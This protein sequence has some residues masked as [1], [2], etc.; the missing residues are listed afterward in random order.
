MSFCSLVLPVIEKGKKYVKPGVQPPK[1]VTLH[2]GK[3]GG[4]FYYIEDKHLKN[5]GKEHELVRSKGV[6]ETQFKDI[7][8]HFKS[9]GAESVHFVHKP[10]VERNAK[11]QKLYNVYIRHKDTDQKL[12][13][14]AEKDKARYGHPKKKP[15]IT[16]EQQHQA[17]MGTKSPK[18]YLS[19][20]LRQMHPEAPQ[21]AIESGTRTAVAKYNHSI[22][23]KKPEP[24]SDA[25]RSGHM[26]TSV[27]KVNPPQYTTVDDV[28]S[29]IMAER[30][31]LDQIK[32]DN[33]TRR[34]FTENLSGMPFS[35]WSDE[36]GNFYR[37]VK[38]PGKDKTTNLREAQQHKAN[39][40]K[41]VESNGAYILLEPEPDAE[42]RIKRSTEAI[43]KKQDP[44]KQVF[45]KIK[46]RISE[47]LD[48]TQSKEKFTHPGVVKLTSNTYYGRDQLTK[49][50]WKYDPDRR[51]W[52]K[53][54][55]NQAEL[56]QAMH[57]MFRYGAVYIPEDPRLKAEEEARKQTPSF[58]EEP[59]REPFLTPHY[60]GQKEIRTNAP[61]D[62]QKDQINDLK[63][64][65]WRYD[66]R[67]KSWVKPIKNESDWN[68][69]NKWLNKRNLL[70]SNTDWNNWNKFEKDRQ[71]WYDNHSPQAKKQKTNVISITHNAM[72]RRGWVSRM[73]SYQ[74][75]Q[76]IDN[77]YG[78]DF[79][80]PSE[81]TNG[82]N[83]Y[84][85]L[86]DGLYE[87]RGSDD[88][89]AG[90][91]VIQNGQKHEITTAEF[92]DKLR[93]MPTM[94]EKL[95]HLTTFEKPV[96][97]FLHLSGNTY[98]HKDW[99]K[100]KGGRWNPYSKSWKI[101]A[102]ENEGELNRLHQ[103]I[104]SRSL[105]SEAEPSEAGKRIKG[106]MS[107]KSKSGT[108]ASVTA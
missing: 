31:K 30:K 16:T 79:I 18:E 67:T 56:D 37:K 105:I 6:T 68:E 13:D 104:S 102:P 51:N 38:E 55:S 8:A 33:L 2:R 100:S 75:T 20:K 50:G 92:R 72:K 106:I 99:I 73:H 53:P 94:I 84:R 29:E 88:V 42:K 7:E 44:P 1:G 40:G 57:G 41:F 27:M 32:P 81:F 63:R 46:E 26:H 59:K 62:K 77:Q 36:N 89:N 47:N 24:L 65:G 21:S 103:E 3:R 95:D 45:D 52:E 39:G 85:D 83:H 71:F 70:F 66:N 25:I 4:T 93:Q 101:P 54:V 69:W 98:E 80:E 108:S 10:N 90:H 60:T 23:Q 61:A 48:P 78:R 22:L 64:E 86:S 91:F 12:A 19:D 5:Q 107:D 97:K 17:E 74:P 11:G 43:T 14:K 58:P 87:Y 82:T 15:E 35:L 96:N 28:R 9:K 76:S 34:Y 49:L